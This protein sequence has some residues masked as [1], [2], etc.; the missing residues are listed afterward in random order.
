MALHKGV[1]LVYFFFFILRLCPLV[2]PVATDRLS[3]HDPL[4]MQGIGECVLKYE[5][6]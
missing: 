4:F 5:R 1:P 6:G 2:F 3:R